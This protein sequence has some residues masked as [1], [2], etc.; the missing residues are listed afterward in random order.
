VVNN[1][2]NN[3][4]NALFESGLFVIERKYQRHV[5]Y[6]IVFGSML[7]T[8]HNKSTQSRMRKHL[9]INRPGR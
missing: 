5:S 2:A 3:D 8:S 1:M 4:G 9:I 7:S 6:Y